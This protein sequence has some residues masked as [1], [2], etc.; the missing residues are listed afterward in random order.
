MAGVAHTPHLEERP[1]GYFFRRRLPKARVEVSNPGQSTA[2]CLNLRTDVLSE[3]KILVARLTVLTDA[4]FALTSERPV[5]QLSPEHVT[6]LTE[7]ARCQIAA[8]EVQRASAE[9]RAPK[10][11]HG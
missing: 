2:L 10:V 1:S 6:L 11:R 7:L 5:D 4:A 8:H 9:P 3:A